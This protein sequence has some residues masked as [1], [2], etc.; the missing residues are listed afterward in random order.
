[1]YQEPRTITATVLPTIPL[2]RGR[3]RPRKNAKELMET[4]NKEMSVETGI[5]NEGTGIQ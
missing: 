5:I 3:G 1:M 2:K 4:Y